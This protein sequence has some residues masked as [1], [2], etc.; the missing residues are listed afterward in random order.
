MSGHIAR[1]TTLEISEHEADLPAAEAFSQRVDRLREAKTPY[2]VD[3]LTV[4]WYEI[5]LVD[6]VSSRQITLNYR[7]ADQGVLDLGGSA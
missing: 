7:D 6:G 3:G 4:T 1:I 2:K 5:S